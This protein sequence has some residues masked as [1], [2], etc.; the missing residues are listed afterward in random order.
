MERVKR[1]CHMLNFLDSLWKSYLLQDCMLSRNL[2]Q[3]IIIYCHWQLQCRFCC[4]TRT[5]TCCG[6]LEMA[7]VMS[8]IIGGLNKYTLSG[9]PKHPLITFC[10]VVFPLML[11]CISCSLLFVDGTHLL[12]VTTSDDQTGSASKWMMYTL[13]QS[14][15]CCSASGAHWTCVQWAGVHGL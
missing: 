12:T 6:K 15:V 5:H 13:L 4:L 10:G 1:G 11:V 3:T 14:S 9:K 8:T 2:A 7:W